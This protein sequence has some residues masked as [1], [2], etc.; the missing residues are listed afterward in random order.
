MHDDS[1][2]DV[3]NIGLIISLKYL[4]KIAVVYFYFDKS[5]TREK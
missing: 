3:L 1:R 2:A 5:H 4:N